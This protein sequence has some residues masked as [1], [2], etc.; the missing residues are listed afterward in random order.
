MS[1]ISNKSSKYGNIRTTVGNI[2]F[3]CLPTGRQQLENKKIPADYRA[4]RTNRG[5]NMS[6]E[7]YIPEEKHHCCDN[8][9]HYEYEYRYWANFCKL[10]KKFNAIDALNE[11]S[12]CND[13][14]SLKQKAG[15]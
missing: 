6:K 2:T 8:C 7:P 12:A 5:I 3:A 10:H 9:K 15:D 13:W 4:N 14:A 11:K 1:W